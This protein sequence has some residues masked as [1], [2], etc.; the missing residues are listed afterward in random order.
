MSIPGKSHEDIRDYEHPDS[1]KSVYPHKNNNNNDDSF[2][3]VLFMNYLLPQCFSQPVA[4][5][6]VAAGF[7][8][9]AGALGIVEEV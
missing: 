3:F 2:L 4:G 7:L 8:G 9:E 1:D 6:V 5:E